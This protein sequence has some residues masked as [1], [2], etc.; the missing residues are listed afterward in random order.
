MSVGCSLGCTECDGGQN[1]HGGTNPN[2]KDRCSS[3]TKPWKVNDP[4]LRTFNR[5]CTGDCIG[6]DADWTKFVRVKRSST[7]HL[8]SVAVRTRGVS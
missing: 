4:L 3:G 8:E 1:G 7:L 2:S 6:T 5:N